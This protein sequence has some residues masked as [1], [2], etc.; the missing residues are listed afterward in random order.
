MSSV[1]LPQSVC[2]I[3]SNVWIYALTVQDDQTKTQQARDLISAQTSIVLSTQV[4]NEVCVNLL[5]KAKF[6]EEEIRDVADDFFSQYRVLEVDQAVMRRA[7]LLREQHHL[8]F[9]DSLIVASA[10]ASGAMALYT[11]DM[12]DGLVIESLTIINPFRMS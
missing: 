4:V 12:H 10:L 6:T 5:K 3:D 8:S 11:E 9:W 7:S 2:F 1:A